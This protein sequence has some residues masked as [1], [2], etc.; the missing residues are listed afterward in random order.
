[1]TDEEKKIPEDLKKELLKKTKEDGYHSIEDFRGLAK[2]HVVWD[3]YLDM[4]LKPCR[5]EIDRTRC[6]G[7]GTCLLPAHCDALLIENG[8][9]VCEVDECT[10]CG[11][12]AQLCPQNAI[13]IAPQKR[14]RA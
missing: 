11:L 14:A 13:T 4:E 2:K 7:C 3:M 6:N 12:C 1:M 9:A 5:P 8:I 10:G